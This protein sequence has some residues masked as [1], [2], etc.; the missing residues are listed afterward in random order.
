MNTSFIARG[1]DLRFDGKNHVGKSNHGNQYDNDTGKTDQAL[2]LASVRRPGLRAPLLTQ[3]GC[4][5]EHEY[6]E[7]PK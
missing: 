3:L 7:E 2:S 4:T 1:S 6:P 5:E